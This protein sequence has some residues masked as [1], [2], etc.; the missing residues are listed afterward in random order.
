M[1]YCREC[2][3]L[4]RAARDEEPQQFVRLLLWLIRVTVEL[5]L[6]WLV[7]EPIE[8][9]HEQDLLLLQPMLI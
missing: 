6:L 4:H 9:Q 7:L 2:K 5:E 8:Q 3:P 1:V